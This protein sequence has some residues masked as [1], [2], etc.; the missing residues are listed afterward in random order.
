MFNFE[1]K[2]QGTDGEVERLG[3]DS[4]HLHQDVDDK[5]TLTAY[6]TRQQLRNP[7]GQK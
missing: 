2:V 5:I 6:K 1:G 3:V 4:A 7:E